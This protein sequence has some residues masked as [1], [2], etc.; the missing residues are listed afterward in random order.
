MD[1][2]EESHLRAG[3]AA[4][5]Q[6]LGAFIVIRGEAEIVVYL[7]CSWLHGRGFKIIK[8]YRSHSGDRTFRRLDTAWNFTRE[9]GLAGAVMVY[10]S[11][12]PDLAAFAGVVPRDLIAVSA[13]PTNA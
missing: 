9:F 12:D 1:A 8:S 5:G 7:R 3:I 2:L 6:V 11:G 10:P 4:G 13:S